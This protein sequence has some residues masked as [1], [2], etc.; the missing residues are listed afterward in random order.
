MVN[1]RWD[2]TIILL[3]LCSL[4]VLLI[5]R[6]LCWK[7]LFIKRLSTLIIIY[8]YTESGINTWILSWRTFAFPFSVFNIFLEQRVFLPL[9]PLHNQILL[10]HNNFLV[11]LW[12]LHSKLY[13]IINFNTCSMLYLSLCRTVK[14]STGFCWYCTIYLTRN[15]VISNLVLI[16]S[17]FLYKILTKNYYLQTELEIKSH[18]F[19]HFF[20]IT[21]WHYSY[22]VAKL[23]VNHT[24]I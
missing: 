9:L 20:F 16:H 15:C 6:K 18:S 1:E 2:L 23:R 24:A 19:W 4:F 7:K 14:V 5:E 13:V 10:L 3:N 17:Y 8:C 21:D 11:F 12:F 22:R